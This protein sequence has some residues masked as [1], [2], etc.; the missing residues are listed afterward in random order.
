MPLLLDAARADVTE[1]E[2][3]AALQDVWGVYAEAPV[4]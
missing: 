1:G 2:L 3:V 4:F